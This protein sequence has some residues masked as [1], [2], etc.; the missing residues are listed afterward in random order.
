MIPYRNEKHLSDWSAVHSKRLVILLSTSKHGRHSFSG[1]FPQPI[2]TA[3]FQPQ[4]WSQI[5]EIQYVSQLCYEQWVKNCTGHHG[6][7]TCTG[8]DSGREHAPRLDLLAV[9]LSSTMQEHALAMA[10]WFQLPMYISCKQDATTLKSSCY[11][12]YYVHMSTV[13][14]YSGP[15]LTTVVFLP[16]CCRLLCITWKDVRPRQ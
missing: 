13:L 1:L 2:Y 3:G 16:S 8:V 11:G 4:P 7:R 5:M 15:T 12:Q 14:P 9:C 10:A 6:N